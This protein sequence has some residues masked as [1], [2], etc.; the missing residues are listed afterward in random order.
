MTW[1]LAFFSADPRALSDVY[2]FAASMSSCRE[3]QCVDGTAAE[4]SLKGTELRRRRPLRV[5]PFEPRPSQQ[6]H[7]HEYDRGPIRHVGE[8]ITVS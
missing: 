1:P 6:S 5:V 4:T 7:D 8:L 3:F 2:S